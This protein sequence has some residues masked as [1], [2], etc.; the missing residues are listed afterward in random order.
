MKQWTF[1]FTK[2]QFALFIDSVTFYPWIELMRGLFVQ[3]R[4]VANRR[5]RV[6][7]IN[8]NGG[9]NTDVN[10]DK[11]VYVGVEDESDSEDSAEE[12]GLQDMWNEM[13]MALEFSKV[14]LQRS[15]AI[16]VFSY[17]FI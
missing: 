16:I 4:D 3:V 12:D 1:A 8:I 5:V 6:E 17:S 14:E 10:R 7:P 15:V 2:F 9:T 13:S 11:G